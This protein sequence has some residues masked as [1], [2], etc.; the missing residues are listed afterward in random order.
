[1]ENTISV[2]GPRQL[3]YERS[4]QLVY[5]SSRSGSGSALTVIGA[6][7]FPQL[8]SLLATAP[9]GNAGDQGEAVAVDAGRNRVYL[10][11]VN[12]DANPDTVSVFDVSNPSAPVVTQTLTAGLRPISI[13]VDKDHDRVYV[14]NRDSGTLSIYDAFNNLAPGFVRSSIPVGSQPS[15][16]LYDSFRDR[17]VVANQGDGTVTVYDAATLDPTPLFTTAVPSPAGLLLAP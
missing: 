15:A 13:A 11:N 14:L 12:A 1:M 10:S 4:R 2:T 3:E 17:I 8:P 5:V 6:P 9:A 7:T 16:V